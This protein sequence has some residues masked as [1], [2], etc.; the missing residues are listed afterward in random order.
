LISF[1]KGEYM[2][3]AKSIEFELLTPERSLLKENTEFV[4]LPGQRGELGVLPGHVTLLTA[5][6][7]GE[8]RIQNNQQQTKRF[9]VSGG[10]AE[11]GPHRVLVLADTAEAVLEIDM[12]R[13]RKA[14]QR[15]LDRLAEQT[16]QWDQTRAKAALLRAE[17]RLKVASRH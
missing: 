10:F 6:T 5:L 11:V 1:S 16:E 3:E 13:A 4:V 17:A 14:R 8:V 2:T 7:F 15:A 9:V 12:D